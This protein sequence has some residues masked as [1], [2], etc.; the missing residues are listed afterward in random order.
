MRLAAGVERPNADISSASPT[1]AEN[2]LRPRDT[3]QDFHS[4]F[5]MYA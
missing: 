3:L 4:C 5:S 2:V 1:V